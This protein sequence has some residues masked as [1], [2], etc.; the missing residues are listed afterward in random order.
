MKYFCLADSPLGKL[1][2]ISNGKSLVELLFGKVLKEGLI[3]NE[4]LEIFKQTKNWLSRYFKGENPNPSE[5]SLELNGSVFRKKV[6]EMLLK[7]PYGKTK[8]YKEISEIVSPNKKLAARA[9]G[10]AISKNPIPII[11]P[12]HRVIGSNGKLIG[13]S[14]GIEKKIFLLSHENAQLKG[15]Q[16]EKHKS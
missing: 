7:I 16:H 5:L 9:V 11:I 1:T 13:Y 12:C 6:W 2:L 15:E 8:S 10:L 14:G 3:N 4:N